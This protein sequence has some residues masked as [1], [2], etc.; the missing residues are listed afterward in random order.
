MSK[1][2][3]ILESHGLCLNLGGVELLHDIDCGVRA[4][5]FA[6]IVG[7]NGAGKSTLLK[8]L[9]MLY[10]GWSGTVSLFGKNIREYSRRELARTVG[11][12]P[13]HTGRFPG[14]SV[15]EFL[16]MSRYA[17]HG[18]MGNEGDASVI[19]QAL[20]LTGTTGLKDRAMDTLSGGESQKVLIAAALAQN[21]KIILL[22]EP[23]SFLDP[24]YRNE[25]HS[26]LKKLNREKGIAVLMVSHDIN[27]AALCADRIIALKAGRVKHDCIPEE[28]MN[29][30]V[31]DDLF[32][33]HFTLSRHPSNGLTIV[34]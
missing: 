14:F 31:L 9:D 16:D 29:Q 6:A 11:Y 22:D 4:G 5:E 8:C 20:E 13:Q 32:D 12:V 1:Q 24:K 34:V 18:F 33:T 21:A 25:V 17:W 19:G 3:Y 7:P 28:F 15:A 2:N 10:T 27:S 23:T 26:L 30:A